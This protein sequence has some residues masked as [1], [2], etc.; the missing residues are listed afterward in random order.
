MKEEKKNVYQKLQ[1]CRTELQQKDL[2]KSGENKFAGFKYFELADFLPVINTLFYEI[3]LSSTFN[4]NEE[5]NIATLTIINT[6]NV[7]ET[8][9]FQTPLAEA[10]IK[11]CAPIQSLGGV[12]TYLRRYLYMNALEIVESDMFDSKTGDMEV[13]D[14]PK[15]VTRKG[16]KNASPK[17][18]AMLLQSYK[19]DNLK[20]LLEANGIEKIEDLPMTK[21]SELISKIMN[22]KDTNKTEDENPTTDV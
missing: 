4:I 13:E 5:E 11:G 18:V 10:N 19:G 15:K 2:K 16:T 7:E 6:D 21:A 1:Q 9:V 17:Q 3:G 22:L 20:K 14:K 12:H 8:I